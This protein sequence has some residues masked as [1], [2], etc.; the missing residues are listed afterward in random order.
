V[1]DVALDRLLG[2][3]EAIA[4]LAVDEAFGDELEDL[5]LSCRRKMLRVWTCP[6]RGELDELY[7]RR[8]ARG[9]R[10]EAARMLAIP[11]QDFLTLSCVHVGGIGAPLRG[12]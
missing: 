8:A 2:E 1:A 6:A 7:R 4:D 9:D 10:L 5:D 3:V 12:L 11:G